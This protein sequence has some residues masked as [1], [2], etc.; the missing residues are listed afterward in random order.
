MTV[1][2]GGQATWSGVSASTASD[3]GLLG[4]LERVV[5]L[6]AEIPDGAFKLRVAEEQLYGSEVAGSPVDQGWLRTPNRVRSIPRRI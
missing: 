4:D 6:N 2:R 5:N 1:R 3:F